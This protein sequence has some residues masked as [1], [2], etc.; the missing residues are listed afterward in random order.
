MFRI[1]SIGLAAFVSLVLSPPQLAAQDFDYKAILAAGD[2]ATFAVNAAYED[3]QGGPALL[4]FAV[5][6]PVA[7]GQVS[8][9]S[10]TSR[11]GFYTTLSW[12]STAGQVAEMLEFREATMDLGP[13]DDRVGWL[14]DMIRDQ[15]FPSLTSDKADVNL[16]GVRQITAGT[17]PA[18]E[19][20]STYK[21]DGLGTIIF[22]IVGVFPPQG[23]N[24]LL[25]I[26]HTIVR[27]VPVEKATLMSGTLAGTTLDSVR[28]I[29][30][31][32]PDGSLTA[33]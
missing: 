4:H 13:L 24:L 12:Y 23:E 7:N 8:V 1:L 31:R 17:Y 15:V 22:R 33:F 21:Q 10:D 26:S 14:A 28:F 27:M 3:A 19:L 9:K 20:V 18:V 11:D 29:A 16:I 25:A 32:G 6:V 5:Q 30:T 2:T